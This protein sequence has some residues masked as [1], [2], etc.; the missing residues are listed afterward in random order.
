MLKIFQ[1]CGGKYPR[2]LWKYVVGRILR[3][4]PLYFLMLLFV[5]KVVPVIGGNGPRFYQFEE[6]HGCSGTI[7]WH[8]L[9]L[10]NIFPWQQNSLCLEQTWY[11]A[12]DV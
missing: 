5:W 9:Y 2:P 3:F 4:T 1:L 12:N 8:M 11:L 6:D 7:I 10:N